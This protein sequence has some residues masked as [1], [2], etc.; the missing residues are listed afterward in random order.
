MDLTRILDKRILLADDEPGVREAISMLL[1]VDGHTVTG[2]ANGR[3][4]LH[5][6][7]AEHFDVVITDFAMPEMKGNELAAAIRRLAPTQPIIMITAY[8]NSLIGAD[9]PVDQVLTK[10]F[11]LD[12]LR[13]AIAGVLDPYRAQ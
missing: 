7:Q 3:E 11:R 1:T 5:L 8:P 2:A 12:D 9:N 13:Q 4:A 6:F 10:P